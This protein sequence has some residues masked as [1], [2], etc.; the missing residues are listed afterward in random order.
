MNKKVFIGL[1]GGVD[2]AVSAALLQAAGFEVHAVFLK[3]WSESKNLKGECAWRDE[4]RMAL[5]VA[6]QL[7][8]TFRTL[9]YEERFQREVI[10]YL[11][12]EYA[13]GR[14]P[15]PDVMCNK[16]V[17][18]DALFA[19]ADRVGAEWVATG[20]YARLGTG[21]TGTD[22]EGI[23]PRSTCPRL[24]KGADKNKDQSYFLHQLNPE[25]LSRLKF[26]VGEMT[27]PEVRAL[28]KKF[29]LPNADKEDSVGICFVGE[30]P[31][32]DFLKQKIKMRPGPVMLIDEN[33]LPVRNVG[34]HS[35]LE[36]FTI[37][38]RHGFGGGGGTPYFVV[39]KNLKTNTLLVADRTDHPA[40][41]GTTCRVSNPHFL[42]PLEDWPSMCEV[43][44]RYRHEGVSSTWNR[45]GEDFILKFSKS[46]RAVTSGQFA[47]LYDNDVCLGGGVIV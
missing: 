44:I 45:D 39:A 7:G 47:V 17:K 24:L 11:F 18:F 19:S 22:P 31:L 12:H 4:R 8:I 23:C 9:D 1:S 42:S 10:D 37:G 33:G 21:S 13:A 36:Q 3:N 35:G 41:M 38:Q 2:S 16:Y 34:E 46:Q 20:H 40:L 30:V 29:N 32:G 6:A 15:N 25:Y 27:K 28:A 26:P 43:K 14:T 5:R